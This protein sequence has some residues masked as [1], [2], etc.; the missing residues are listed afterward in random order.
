MT[1]PF[2]KPQRAD[3]EAMIRLAVPV[4]IVQVGMMLFGVVDTMVVGRLSSQALAA[5]ALGHIAVIT[6]SSFGVGVLLGLDPLLNQ[7]LGA[8]DQASFRRS[9]QR[10]F[11]ISVGLM[12]PSAAILVP[13]GPILSLLGQPPEIVPL[14]AAYAHIS[15]PGLLPFY[16][17]VVLRLTLQAMGRLRPIV[18]T[19]IAVN[20]FNLVA[21]WV[22]VFGAGPIPQ[23]GPLGSAWA[24]TIARTLLFVILLVVDRW[25]LWPLLRF[26]REAFRLQP[27]LRTV[28]L[29]VPIGFQLQ[30][31]IVAFTVIALLMGGMGTTVM[32]AHQVAINLASL[33]FM[34]P[35]GV[36]QATAVRVGNA[37][38]AGNSDGARRAASSGLLLGA[39]FMALTAVLFIGLP[40]GLARAY[41]SVDEVRFL[42]ATLIPIAGFFQVFDGLQVVSAGVLRGAGDTR[43][44]LVINLVGFWLIGLP[45][46]LLLGFT[47][48]L[49]PQGLWWGLVVGLGAVGFILLGRVSARLRGAIE[50]V[51]ID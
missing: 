46:S 49:G 27:L 17:W 43:A 35:L 44:P 47:F 21:D 45:A 30:L 19:V 12:V 37:I 25:D 50:R 1:R 2:E 29:G 16:C 14:A 20:L 9:V 3:L 28:R 7:A 42:A 13:I 18:A 26:D 24:S 15:I 4:V 51:A 40:G 5:V 31:E 36:A 10:G 34:V 32:A 22:L 33:T 41:T 6:V 38:G 48:G 23:L 8:R 39:G 11:A